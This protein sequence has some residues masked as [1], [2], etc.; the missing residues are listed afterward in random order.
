MTGGDAEKHTR[1]RLGTFRIRPA[2]ACV[3]WPGAQTA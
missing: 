3:W 2:A 1:R